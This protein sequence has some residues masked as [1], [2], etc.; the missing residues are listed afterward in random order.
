ME[1]GV[2]VTSCMVTPFPLFVKVYS[3]VLPGVNGDV[4]ILLSCRG[5]A[6]RLNEIVFLLIGYSNLNGVLTSIAC[7][8]IEIRRFWTLS[9]SKSTNTQHYTQRNIRWR[10]CSSLIRSMILTLWPRDL[11]LRSLLSVS[12]VRCCR[13]ISPSTSCSVTAAARAD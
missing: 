4:D 1:F 8:G 3:S 12:S 11:I 9:H 5:G 13:R 2:P 7:I 6:S 10:L